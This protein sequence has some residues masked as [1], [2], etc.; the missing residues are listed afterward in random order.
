MSTWR[1]STHRDVRLVIFVVFS[2]FGLVHADLLLCTQPY[3]HE[4]Q[5]DLCK[6][7]I[8]QTPH[9]ALATTAEKIS[10]CS[11]KAMEIVAVSVAR[12][13]EKHFS[14]S[15]PGHLVETT[16]ISSAQ[17]LT[18][19][20]T[21][22]VATPLPRFPSRADMDSQG[23]SSTS[24]A[25]SRVGVKLSRRKLPLQTGYETY[26]HNPQGHTNRV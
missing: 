24:S 4:L 26:H 21:F 7:F 16:T 17:R 18:S 15:E 25:F 19:S 8:L 2:L 10:S 13:G 11:A 23:Q 6:V 22:G 20:Y 9:P 14:S 3:S 1:E 5:S 12:T